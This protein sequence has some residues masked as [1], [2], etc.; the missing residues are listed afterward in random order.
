[1]KRK[2]FD[3]KIQ[4]IANKKQGPWELINW[5]NKH[6]LLTI[7]MIKYNGNP[8]LEL[9]D[10]WQALHSSFNSAQF[11][12][13]DKMVLNELESFLSSTWLDFLEEEFTY[14]IINC[15]NSSASGPNKVLWEYLKH[16]IINKSCLKNIVFIANMCFKL[17]YWPSHFKESTTIVIPK[18][19]KSFYNLLKSFRP[20]VL[21]NTLSKLI[22]KAIG[23]R[24]QF[25]VITNNFIYQ[26]QLGGLKFKSTIDTDI[27][28]TH[29]ICTGWIKNMLTST[30]A[31]DIAQFFPSL[32]HCLLSLIL[33]KV[34]SRLKVINFFSNYL[35]NRK[36]AYSWNNFSSHLFDVNV[37]VGQGSALSPILST[38]YLSPFLYILEKYLKNLDLKISILSFVDDGLL[39]SQGK[40]FQLSN[41]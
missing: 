18:S 21:L 17:G 34:G 9:A 27:A 8:C 3:L 32:N 14:T 19:N 35:I 39:I 2:F 10:L 23:E 4:E 25:Q 13:I 6:K 16:I 26:S 31:F 36:T 22:E 5:V 41:A 15:Y 28:L 1:M 38:L 40:Y 30:L 24:L 29:F 7:E 12:M 33:G 37:E 20:I 11:Q